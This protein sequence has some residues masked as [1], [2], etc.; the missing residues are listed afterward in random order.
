VNHEISVIGY[1]NYRQVQTHGHACAECTT[2]ERS[3]GGGASDGVCLQF[4][5][6]FRDGEGFNAV[7]VAKRTFPA[8]KAGVAQVV[9]EKAFVEKIEMMGIR[10][11]VPGPCTLPH[12]AHAEKKEAL[13]RGF[14][15]PCICRIGYHAVIFSGNMTASQLYL[16]NFFLMGHYI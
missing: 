1:G 4:P 7:V 2:A 5:Q 6:K 10:E 14:E 9:L 11:C 3:G 8:E 16:K 15:Q 12:S 13:L